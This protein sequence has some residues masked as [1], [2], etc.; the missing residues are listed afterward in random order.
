MTDWFVYAEVPIGVV[1]DKGYLEVAEIAARRTYPTAT[2]TRLKSMASA[3]LNQEQRTKLERVTFLNPP[4][5]TLEEFLR[6]VEKAPSVPRSAC[7]ASR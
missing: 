5:L 1:R 3:G 4:P 7:S 6:A 2:I